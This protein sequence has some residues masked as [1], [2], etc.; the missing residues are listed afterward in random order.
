[1]EDIADIDEYH[2]DLQ[3]LT[4]RYGVLVSI[5]LISDFEP[6]QGVDALTRYYLYQN[7]IPVPVDSIEVTH[8]CSTNGV[9][10][11]R[12]KDVRGFKHIPNTLKALEKI[13]LTMLEVYK[14]KSI[15]EALYISFIK[16]VTNNIMVK[17]CKCCKKFFIPGGRSDTEYCDRLA[18]ESSKT[19]R[20]IG[21]IK[22]YHKK[23]NDNPI[24]KEFQKEYK[25]MNSRVRIKKITQNQFYD[26][27]EKARS[28]RDRAVKENMEIDLFIKQLKEMEV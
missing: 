8:F 4:I 5:I 16:M 19:C 11:S 7:E 10:F 6:L 22:K 1:L 28:F 13:E 3:D 2:I 20:E 18:P 17:K 23:S 15:E 21:A 14:V 12:P 9:E 26:W 27:S 25:K 24:M